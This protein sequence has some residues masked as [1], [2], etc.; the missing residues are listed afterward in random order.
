MDIEIQVDGQLF[1]K[2]TVKGADLHTI[3]VSSK[4][5]DGSFVDSTVPLSKVR[6]P[7]SQPTRAEQLLP[8]SQVEVK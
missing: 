6:L 4:N 1:A 5:T 7:P 2:G 8:G 3:S